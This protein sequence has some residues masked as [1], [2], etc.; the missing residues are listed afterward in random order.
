MKATN[1]A[2]KVPATL[3]ADEDSVVLLPAFILPLTA[4]VEAP[5][6]GVAGVA[7]LLAVAVKNSVGTVL[8]PATVVFGWSISTVWV[9]GSFVPLAEAEARN[10][11]GGALDGIVAGVSL[12][13]FL[14]GRSPEFDAF[15]VSV[16][17]VLVSWPY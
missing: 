7:A 5:L 6:A 17:M 14:A 8:V 3:V 4:P 16:G 12:S 15:S 2:T 11:L 10:S 9:G 1:E 13:I